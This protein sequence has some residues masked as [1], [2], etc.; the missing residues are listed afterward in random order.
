MLLTVVTVCYNAENTIKKTMDSVI[1]Q[2]WNRE[3]EYLIVDGKST[4]KTINIIEES[5]KDFPKHMSYEYISE[6][7]R[8]V[9][10]A[11][12]KAAAQARG[13]WILYMNADDYFVDDRVVESVFH[14]RCYIWG[15]SVCS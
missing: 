11:M 12:N 8:G 13:E 15:Y 5:V 2:T 14:D 6:R 10:D 9:Y 7:D 4:D 3:I 1:R